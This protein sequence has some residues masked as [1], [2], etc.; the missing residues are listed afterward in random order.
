M[1]LT[2]GYYEIIG[3]VKE[4]KSVKA[5]T[6]IELGPTLGQSRVHFFLSPPLFRSHEPRRRRRRR[7]VRVTGLMVDM[8]SVNAVVELAQ[9]EKGQG[10]LA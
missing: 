3:S 8:A 5:L 7:G 9:T 2:E 4:D 10:V 6:S 1:H